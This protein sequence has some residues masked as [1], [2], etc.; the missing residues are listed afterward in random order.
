MTI[1]RIC[2][3]SCKQ[4]VLLG[5]S[6]LGLIPN[7]TFSEKDMWDIVDISQVL[8]TLCTLFGLS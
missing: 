6:E 1:F 4:Q 3:K 5:Y 7:V 2:F 8:E